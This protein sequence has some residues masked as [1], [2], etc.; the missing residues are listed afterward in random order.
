MNED[1]KIKVLH[2]DDD[3]AFLE[4]FRKTY[5]DQFEIASLS[6]GDDVPE[7]VSREMPDALV[8]D[9]ELP[10]RNGLE[11]LSAI[12]EKHPSLP[13]VF[14]TGQ[15]NEEVARL[16]F[17]EGATDYF[18]KRTADFAQKEKLV[19]SVRKAVKRRAVEEELA[20]KQAMLEGIIENNPY[21]IQIF[22]SEGRPLRANKAHRKLYGASPL[23][24]GVDFDEE[25]SIPDDV[26]D[27]IR[28][29]WSGNR[30]NYRVYDDPSVN[31]NDELH[32]TMVEWRKGGVIKQPPIW[33]K[34][35]F[36]I[37]SGTMKPV[38]ISTTGFSVKNHHGRIVNYV[39]MHED[40]T[41]RVEAE[42]ALKKA[43]ED[44]TIAHEELRKAYE[45]TEQKVTERTAEL[46][47]ANTKL[48]EVNN[49]FADANNH[50]TD[51]NNRL[52]EA[53]TKL[54]DANDRLTD[55]NTK[56]QAEIDERVR[57]QGQLERQNSELEGFSHTVSHDLRNNLIVM[58]RLMERGNMAQ[59]DR[60]KTQELL[61]NNTAHLQQFVERLL[62]LAQA[63]KTIAEKRKVSLDEAA[64][65]AFSMAAASHADAELSVISPFPPVLCDPQAFEQIFSNLFSNSLIYSAAGVKPLI[66][67]GCAVEDSTAEITVQD[68]GKGIEPGI[69]SRI[70]DS[71]FTTHR[72]EHFGLGL[73]IVKKLVEAHGG[74]VRAE[75]DGPGR[76]A[77]FIITLPYET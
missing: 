51:A 26:K 52:A 20:E 61:L 70:F 17:R 75:S 13:V 74:T 27:S 48:A 10:G 71:T 50:L 33:Y 63:G 29:E 42:E 44:L 41:A 76:G 72:N 69:I 24:D 19:N 47:E 4:M 77:A 68:N 55:T 9:Y 23:P 1:R 60:Q 58:Q 12:R 49:R 28:E 38:C 31:I 37:I 14:Y 3:E 53:N 39:S 36:P 56:L 46:A 6:G 34:I 5:G 35:P 16:A 59:D 25:L 66:H 40:I 15:G 32:K 43:H 2:I 18:V 65:K 8:L 11:L 73:A 54:A 45:S 7:I 22:D 64:R 57:L 67:V 62:F 30:D 21:S